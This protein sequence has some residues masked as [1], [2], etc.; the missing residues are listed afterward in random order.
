MNILKGRRKMSEV[1]I[2]ALGAFLSGAMHTQRRRPPPTPE[3]QARRVQETEIAAWNAAV[4]AR[5]DA[6]R[7]AKA[8]RK[9]GGTT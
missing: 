5:K 9:Q 7:L 8:K 3:Q 1:E 4:D 6:K 2:A